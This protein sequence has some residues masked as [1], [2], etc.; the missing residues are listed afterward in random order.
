MSNLNSDGYC[1]YC[2]G[3][4]TTEIGQGVRIPCF[5]VFRR[6]FWRFSA[7][8]KLDI[9][10]LRYT[11]KP[12]HI[13]LLDMKTPFEFTAVQLE[14]FKIRRVYH[15]GGGEERERQYIDGNPLHYTVPIEEAF[16][17]AKNLE[18]TQFLLPH[19]DIYSLMGRERNK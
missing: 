2:T 19:L 5:L 10:L 18:L 16:K 17:Y 4:V 8:L 3:E 13:R 1:L 15:L 9:Q 11:R 12:C 6:W 7:Y 14:R